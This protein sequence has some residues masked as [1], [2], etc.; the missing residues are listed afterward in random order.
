MGFY[1]KMTGMI[2]TR[3]LLARPMA[4]TTG[5]VPSVRKAWAFAGVCPLFFRLLTA[6]LLAASSASAIELS[7]QLGFVPWKGTGDIGNQALSLGFDRYLQNHPGVMVYEYERLWLPGFQ[8][9]AAQVM[10]V[11]GTA[12]PDMLS[13]GFS[14]LGG[15][16][17][18]GLVQPVDDLYEGWL[19]KDRWPQSLVEGLK[20]EGRTWGVLLSA[21]Y[22]LLAGNREVFSAAGLTESSMPRSWADL[23]RVAARLVAPGK[24]AGLAFA[25]PGDVAAL[26]LALAWQAGG[27]EPVKIGRD[28]LEVNLGTE[29]ARKAA[30]ALAGL[31]GVLRAAGPGALIVAKNNDELYSAF[32]DGRVAVAVAPIGLINDSEYKKGLQPQNPH[33]AALPGCFSADPLCYATWGNVGA[34]PGY[35]RDGFRRKLIWEFYTT[36][37]EAGSQYDRDM[38][39][40]ALRWSGTPKV[41][42][43]FAALYPGHPAV[44]AMPA[45]WGAAINAAR[46]G[47][48]PVPPDSDWNSLA[49]QL[50]AKLASLMNEGGD[51][52][53]TLRLAQEAFDRDVRNLPRHRDT[54]W[55]I[56]G[57]GILGLIA[58]LLLYGLFRLVW[59]FKDELAIYRRAPI[60]RMTRAK[61]GIS[62][63]LFGPAIA[64]ALVFGVLPLLFGLK[65]SLFSHVLREGGNFIGAANFYD[66]IV[67][68]LTQKAVFNTAY[69]MFFSF[70]LC[71]IGP[72]VV[73]LALA[74]FPRG[75]FAVRTAFF[76]P[77]VAS[78]VVVAIL[79][80]QMY[81][82]GGAFNTLVKLFGF[83]PRDWLSEP[84][85]AMFATVLP[86]AWASLGVYG[87]I[88]L[89]GVSAIPEDLYEECEMSGA[90]VVER[91]RSITLPFLRP[92]IGISFV[93][94]L[95]SAT[96]TAEHVFLLTGGGPANATY[97]VG[98]DIF[99]RAYAYIKFGYAMAEV[100]LLV[101]IILVFSIYQMR[102]VRAGQLRVMGE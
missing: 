20:L 45:H 28:G 57:W 94:W 23:G 14:E 55:K 25:S 35:I 17:R 36:A 26:W 37:R 56:A 63:A 34:I 81:A 29:S 82:T 84:G 92:L 97:V 102:A 73:A 19:E 76:F 11:A 27:D 43:T 99:M 77:A 31:G 53:T 38:L 24:R 39:A 64:L 78:A 1:C 47:A 21:D 61:L 15:Y 66:V 10:S 87:L 93:G 72:L 71:F 96:R 75:V 69:Y 49:D 100:W 30:E 51:P 98:L 60:Q 33:L 5:R 44:K 6:V 89:A 3:E 91:F 70:F 58:V 101:A 86:Q 2:G 52:A 67:D 4:M 13:L 9:G 79:W 54:S 62:V 68:P 74:S 65:M 83:P 16:V 22:V 88:Y 8:W 48:R 95:L 85:V 42:V 50:G 80:Q 32:T 7:A 90:G 41:P 12:G 46:A 59:T 18:E 40:L